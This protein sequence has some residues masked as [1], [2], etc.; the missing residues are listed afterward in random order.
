MPMNNSTS[1]DNELTHDVTAAKSGDQAA[2]ERVVTS[3]R[4]LVGRLALRFFGCP[5]HAEDATQEVL[6]QVATRL[7]RFEGRSA[8]STW[9][10]RVASN[11]FL[12]MARSPPEAEITNIDDFEADLSRHDPNADWRSDTRDPDQLLLEAEVRIGCTLAMLLVLERETRLAYILGE[13]AELGHVEAAQI[14]D[15]TPAAFRKRLE[16]ARAA[17]VG[18]MRRRC[19]VFDPANSCRC[20]ARIGT[21][22]ARGRLDSERL[23]YASSKEVAKVFPAVLVQIRR[24]TE[25]QRAAALYRSHPDPQLRGELLRELERSDGPG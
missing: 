8:F 3:I 17:I 7:D 25:V 19:G 6:L 1:N 9:V 11:R 24:L 18:V 5:T 20:E 23:L 13:I 15:C 12:S 4:P 14:L 16:R 21:A 10:Y 22:I 2:L